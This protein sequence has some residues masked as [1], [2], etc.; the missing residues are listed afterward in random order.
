MK[1]RKVKAYNA[2]QK[3]KV[4]LRLESSDDSDI[5]PDSFYHDEIDDFNDEK[6]N[7]LS[8]DDE[9]IQKRKHSSDE[10]EVLPITDD[11]KDETGD[12][13]EDENDEKGLPNREAWGKKKSVYYSA[14]FVD[15]DRGRTYREED[16]E[17]AK[18]EEEEALAIQ[19]SVYHN[20]NADNLGAHLFFESGEESAEEEES[21]NKELATKQEILKYLKK[22][23][24][25]FEYKALFESVV[26]SLKKFSRLWH[27][28]ETK[29]I[30]SKQVER[31]IRVK[32]QILN[33]I[34]HN[35]IMYYMFASSGKN[36]KHHPVNQR[37]ALLKQLLD[38]IESSDHVLSPI[39][40][41]ILE[42]ESRD[43]EIDISSELQ[44]D[45][46]EPVC[47][48]ILI[49]HE[50]AI[51]IANEAKKIKK[52]KVKHVETENEKEVISLI[53]E[54][55]EEVRKRKLEQLEQ[56]Q[57]DQ[58]ESTDHPVQEQATAE[59]KRIISYEIAKN[60]G[61]VPQRKKEY[62]NPRVRH[63]M[64]Y[65]KAQIRRKGQVRGVVKEIKRYEGELTGINTTVVK[66]I[67]FK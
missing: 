7:E 47:Q 34:I 23:T 59:E 30:R 2:K 52:S 43:E 62:R 13:E 41:D 11:E 8:T 63:R 21:V 26:P 33:L 48:S 60:K 66:S 65:R 36:P 56:I 37:I 16:A 54:V 50:D 53:K 9:L 61:L 10:E 5:N 14:D 57:D 4:D 29:K 22:E 3:T 18:A 44:M 25:I 40:D 24:K 45:I 17:A 28:I 31:Y 20:I 1:S 64:K 58:P 49:A 51:E 19:K 42:Q 67:K 55:K 38:E 12:S 46:D 15:Q 39:L 27:L 32:K 35:I 6:D